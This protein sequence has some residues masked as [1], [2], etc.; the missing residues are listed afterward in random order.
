VKSEFEV[1]LE[2][3]IERLQRLFEI[4]VQINES[5]EARIKAL[6]VGHDGSGAGRFQGAGGK[7]G[8]LL[9]TGWDPDPYRD[10]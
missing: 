5:L 1:Y 7:A 8:P 2:E 9:V 3:Q 6:E 10:P 4:Q